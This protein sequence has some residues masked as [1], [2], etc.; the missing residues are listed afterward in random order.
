MISVRSRACHHG[1]LRNACYSDV[2]QDLVVGEVAG[3]IHELRCLHCLSC[4]RI[5]SIIYTTNANSK[6]FVFI[7]IDK[8]EISGIGNVQIIACLRTTAAS[9]ATT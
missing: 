3:G 9:S 4:L 5:E 6:D 2:S 8:F 7:L 1:F